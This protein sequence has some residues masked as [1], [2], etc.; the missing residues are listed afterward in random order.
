MQNATTSVSL[1]QAMLT[2]FIYL[3][4]YC[5]EVLVYAYDRSAT[6]RYLI[7]GEIL[8]NRRLKGAFWNVDAL[9][10]LCVVD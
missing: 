4:D 5:Y 8:R 9:S 1:L 3:W 2:A 10:K 7:V 6:L